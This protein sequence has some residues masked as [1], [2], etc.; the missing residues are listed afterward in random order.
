MF[1]TT[2]LNMLSFMWTNTCPPIIL[3]LVFMS[4]CQYHV[5]SNE[6]CNLI[7]V[8]IANPIQI[9][10]ISQ[11]VIFWREVTTSVAKANNSLYHNGHPKDMCFPSCQ[12]VNTKWLAQ[13]SR[14]FLLLFLHWIYRQR[15]SV[16]LYWVATILRWAIVVKEPT[17]RLGDF[18]IFRPSSYSILFMWPW[19]F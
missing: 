19:R 6:I 3:S 9:N 11:D 17:F 2:L 12:Q 5:T 15:V 13:G 1:L 10:L 18:Q 16:T 14:G 4:T 7:D 8:V